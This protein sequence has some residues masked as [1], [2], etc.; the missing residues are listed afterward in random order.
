[1]SGKRLSIKTAGRRGVGGLT[2]VGF[3]Q[4]CEYSFSESENKRRKAS[5]KEAQMLKN[6]YLKQWTR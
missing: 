6:E 1:M 3:L 4:G 5:E 2:G